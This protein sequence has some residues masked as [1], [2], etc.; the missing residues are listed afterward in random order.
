MKKISIIG[1]GKVGISLSAALLNSKFTV[2]ISDKNKDLISNYKN[3]IFPFYEPGVKRIINKNF[4]KLIF[5][6]NAMDAI[7]K[8]D[9]T[10]IVVPT[11]SNRYGGFSNKYILQV[12]ENIKE[13]LIKKKKFH[14]FAL[15]STVVPGSSTL[16]IIPHIEKITKKKINKSFGFCYNPSFIAQGEILKG[17]THPVFS[18]IGYSSKKSLK[19]VK[20]INKS[21][22]EN[23][24]K[25]L[26]MSLTE[27]E[28]TKLASNTYETMRVS[29]V[30]MIA[31]ISNEIGD[32]NVDNITNA[33]TFRFEKRFF[34]GAAPYGG[35]CWPRDNIALSSLINQINLNDN[36]PNAV[37]TFNEYHSKYLK[38]LLINLLKKKKLKIG[39]LGLA[40]KV[41][42]PLITKSFSINLIKSILPYTKN[43]IGYDPLVK[44]SAEKIVKSK[45]FHLSNNITDTRSC[46]VI[47]IAQPL[48]NI[49]Y[50]IFTKK[51]IIDLWR[52]VKNKDIIKSKNYINFGNSKNKEISRELSKK[53]KKIII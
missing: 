47:I 29:F 23:N 14:T 20:D 28:I 30:N 15:V 51:I 25:I 12:F 40:Y 19:A 2:Y 46:D 1:V 8:T 36:I 16:Q 43:I 18:L 5:C 10:F 4:N 13:E 53:I 38:N 33:L 11:N 22:I 44:K 49:D 41:G 35:P 17:I 26:E 3:K 37:D 27:S 34:R 24:S 32:T 45:K 42:T 9:I 50:K 6:E 21:I 48:P 52:V 7:K 31:Q 39:I